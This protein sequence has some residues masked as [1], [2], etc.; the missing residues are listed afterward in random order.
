MDS[1]ANKSPQSDNESNNT[2]QLQQFSDEKTD[3]TAV[4]AHDYHA[5]RVVGTISTCYDA[6]LVVPCAVVVLL[7][8]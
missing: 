1:M 5:T 8:D 2:A 7:M 6:S 4:T 3:S